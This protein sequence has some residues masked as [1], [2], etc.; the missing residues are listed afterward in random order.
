MGHVEHLA[1]PVVAGDD[2]AGAGG[3]D[4]DHLGG[5]AA[6]ATGAVVVAGEL[7]PVAGAQLVLDSHK[8]LGLVGALA[9]GLPVTGAALSGTRQTVPVWASTASTR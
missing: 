9:G 1:A 8:G 5:V 4:R 2:H 7:E 6:E 3:V